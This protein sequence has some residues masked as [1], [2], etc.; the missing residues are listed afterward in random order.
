MDRN[1]E[2][3]AELL[4]H[5]KAAG[6]RVFIAE[7]GTYGFFTDDEGSRV[8]TFGAELGGLRFSGNYKTDNPASSG[9]GWRISDS[10]TG[11]YHAMFDT[12]P[13]RWAVGASSNVRSTTL[14]QY[15]ESYQ[16]SSNFTEVQ[17]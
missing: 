8:V 7:R 14:K 6:F 4:S 17:P 9:T 5:I 2:L 10:D 11:E 15:L 12:P 16:A 3:V 13:P 1:K